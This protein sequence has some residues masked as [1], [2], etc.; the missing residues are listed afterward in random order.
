MGT[1][2]DWATA[3]FGCHDNVHF[4]ADSTV[5]PGWCDVVGV[6]CTRP[7][8]ETVQLQRFE[9]VAVLLDVGVAVA[10]PG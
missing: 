6:C 9:F 7:F 2:T 8:E 5:V 3:C 1:C 4:V 10:S